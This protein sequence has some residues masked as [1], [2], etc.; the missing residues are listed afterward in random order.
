MATDEATGIQVEGGKGIEGPGKGRGVQREVSLKV[1]QSDASDQK[2]LHT[3]QIFPGPG[4]PV[5]CFFHVN[6]FVCVFS[7]NRPP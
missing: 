1:L 6:V 7:V 4:K 2:A 5:S 3:T